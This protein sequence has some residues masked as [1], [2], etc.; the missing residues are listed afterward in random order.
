MGFNAAKYEQTLH[1]WAT[2]QTSFN[3]EIQTDLPALRTRARELSLNNEYAKRYHK[4]LRTQVVGDGFILKNKA[5]NLNGD[6]D[7]TANKKIEDAWLEWSTKQATV[8]GMSLTAAL[9]LIIEQASRDGELLLVHRRGS[10]YG[11]FQYQIQLLE[12]E[13]LDLNLRNTGRNTPTIINGVEVD[14]LGRP[15]A[16]HIYTSHPLQTPY[17]YT[18]SQIARVSAQDMIHIFDKERSTQTRGFPWLGAGLIALKH[19]EE[20]RKSE[21]IAARAASKKLG[22][23]HKPRG[24]DELLGDE[25]DPIDENA[26]ITSMEDS[27][28]AILPEGYS[29]DMYDPKHP[30]GNFPEFVK[31]ILR[32][33]AASV[34]IS[35]H[36]LANDLESTSYSSLRQG[37]I[38]EREQFKEHQRWLIETVLQPIFTEWL[39]ISLIT[40]AVN[41]PLDRFDKWNNPHF[42]GRSY[43][44]VDPA[45]EAIAINTQLTNRLTSPKDLIRNMGGDPDIIL[46]DTIEFEQAFANAGL[47]IPRPSS[48]QV[49]VEEQTEDEE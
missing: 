5:R 10:R 35:Y 16:Y 46:Q 41:L 39:R 2:T 28:F 6:L 47:M 15:L 42:Q 22:A 1:N 24:E 48:S 26:V 37:A 23:I 45:K 34:G 40:Q 38:D 13:H 7:K 31:T 20:Y 43:A 12:A 21:N 30:T 33:I 49:V 32:G 4:L 36:S 3:E 14:D 29:L 17:S 11:R 25:Q 18:Q 19:I 44:W 8:D 27:S 9:K